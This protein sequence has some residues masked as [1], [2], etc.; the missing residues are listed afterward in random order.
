M[1]NLM[2]LLA[3]A[4]T[5]AAAAGCGGP[6]VAPDAA[7]RDAGDAGSEVVGRI[8]DH[9][10]TLEDVDQKAKE[11]DIKPFQ[12][13]HDARKQALD[14]LVAEH[15]LDTEA[16]ARG[17]TRDA[18]V[19]QEVTQKTEE[20]AAE[21]IQEFYD[22]NRNAMQGR[23]LEQMSAQVR[24]FLVNQSRQTAMRELV[25]GLRKSHAASTSLEPPRVPVLVAASDP[26]KGPDGA[27][28][29]ILVFSD[30]Q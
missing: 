21:Q 14:T 26:R 9:E 2:R 5:V 27:P 10:I 19:D 11:A 18:L 23:T 28:V 24:S 15:L 7:S 17:I 29:Q 3:V 8:G 6:A 22:Q 16:A 4:L 13:L 25:A 30:F 20:P 12:A 1:S